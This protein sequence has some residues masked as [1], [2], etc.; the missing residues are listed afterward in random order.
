MLRGHLHVQAGAGSRVPAGVVGR[1]VELAGVVANL[2]AVGD[3][4]P[5]HRGRS[6]RAAIGNV[7]PAIAAPVVGSV[8]G[9]QV[10]VGRAGAPLVIAV[11]AIPGI[12]AGAVV[13]AE[14]AHVC[15]RVRASAVARIAVGAGSQGI[16]VLRAGEAGPEA[17]GPDHR[18]LRV[19]TELIDITP[20]VA[21][22]QLVRRVGKERVANMGV[23]R[24]ALAA[25]VRRDARVDARGRRHVEAGAEGVG[26]LR[27]V[28]SPLVWALGDIP[29]IVDARVVRPKDEAV[30]ALVVR[31][32]GG[33]APLVHVAPV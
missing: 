15:A 29:R 33:R 26:R 17:A 20:G 25:V 7:A 16:P 18:G 22:P 9:P 21:A 5:K 27:P 1:L 12:A 14:T 23:M 19:G 13:R 6:K 30:H 4:G 3:S 2:V 24:S 10:R 28:Y 11:D 31:R 32:D 8:R